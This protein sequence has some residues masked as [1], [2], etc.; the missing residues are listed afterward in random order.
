MKIKIITIL[1][2]MLLI[3]TA[4][5]IVSSLDKN[6]ENNYVNDITSDED[7][8]DDDC[9]CANPNGIGHAFGIMTER[10]LNI[11]PDENSMKP[12][13]MDIPEYFNWMDFEGQDWTTP[14]KEQG[15]CGS[16]WD[17]AALGALEVVL[18]IKENN[19]DL[20][21]DLSE[22]YVLSCLPAAGS[23][24]GGSSWETFYYI[25]SNKTSGNFCNGIIPE[26]CFP[27]R[28]VDKWGFNG[29][30]Y[31]EPVLCDEKCENWESFLIPI[32]DYE[33]WLPDGSNEDR[34]IIKTQIMEYGPVATY[35]MVTYYIH[36][37]DNFIEWGLEHHDPDEYYSSSQ[38]FDTIN[39]AVVIMGWKDDPTIENGGYWICKNSWG[40][41]WGYNGFFNIEYG[42]LRI[43]D[44]LVAWVDFDL[45]EVINWQPVADSGGI[46]YGEIGEEITFDGSESF[47]HEGEIT[48]YEWD[49]GDGN[50]ASGITAAHAYENLG[51]YSVKLTVTDNNGNIVNDTTWAFIGRSNEPPNTPIIN[52]PSEGKNGTEYTYK[53]SALDPDG[54]D[55]F[56]YIYWGDMEPL[57]YWI[58][59]YLSG[60][61]ITLNHTWSEEGEYTIRVI[62]SDKYEFKS[63]WATLTVTM[64]RDKSYIYNLNSWS[65][66][67]DRFPFLEILLNNLMRILL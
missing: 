51:V 28:A 13:V 29:Y 43:D 30:Y 56:F 1:V 7:I 47:D 44:F 55:V 10:T 32:L 20:D 33:Y 57:E 61:K 27:Y 53:F 46:Y 31:E 37:K 41:D 64:P 14:A 34:E 21:V 42:C 45:E 4:L 65:S 50:Y 24:K 26:S 54:D 23:C 16:C 15:N 9:E 60:E 52:G 25:L 59:P 40:S 39:H 62:A 19:S 48:D 2:M 66:L 67:F 35:M 18:N 6:I 36:G 49:F 38:H 17:F 12:V 3:T 11:H 22:Q 5:P 58:G 8:F 63:D